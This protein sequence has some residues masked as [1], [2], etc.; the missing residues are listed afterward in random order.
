MNTERLEML[1]NE[2]KT[3]VLTLKCD[4]TKED[5]VKDA[6]E[7][8][9]ASF[10]ALHVALA[11]AGVAWPSMMITSKGSLDLK[12]FQ[13]V[14]QINL[15]GSVYVAKYASLAM[16]KNKAVNERGE[17][18]VIIFVSS[19]A[20][21]EG[22]RGQ[23]AY[24]ATKGAVN[25]MVMPMARDLGKFG[26]RVLAIAPGIFH[27]PL[28]HNMPKS[29]TDRLNADTPMGR[30]GQPDE[31]AHFVGACI[32]NGYLNGVRLR[33]DGAIKMSNL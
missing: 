12:S 29:V 25:G 1:K 2:L 16:S 24:S 9:V 28:A 6:I 17:K 14:V 5:D 18:G 3:R 30:P 21:E 27:T 23:A 19:V 10:G 26:I 15:M 11:C 20:A 8:T 7:K 32:E 33:I 4:V 13:A 31:F 22:Q